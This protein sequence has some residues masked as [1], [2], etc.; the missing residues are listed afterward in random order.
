MTIK[1]HDRRYA[2]SMA[3]TTVVAMGGFSGLLLFVWLAG[4]SGAVGILTA[5]GMFLAWFYK[6]KRPD[7]VPRKG[8][9]EEG[10]SADA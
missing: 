4:W 7:L 5:A 8:R 1:E 9:R 10:S 3:I 6:G 2:V